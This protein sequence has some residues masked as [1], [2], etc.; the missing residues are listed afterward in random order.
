MGTQQVQVDDISGGK[1]RVVVLHFRWVCL[2]ESSISVQDSVASKSTS[3]LVSP[4]VFIAPALPEWLPAT[5][6]DIQVMLG[7]LPLIFGACQQ[8]VWTSPFPA[9]VAHGQVPNIKRVVAVLG[10]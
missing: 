9:L 2:R 4:G 10:T 7:R 6:V 1:V 3:R 8:T 5:N